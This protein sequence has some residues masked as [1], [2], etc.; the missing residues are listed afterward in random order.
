MIS[1]SPPAPPTIGHPL[2]LAS[3]QP[4]RQFPFKYFVHAVALSPDA[5][6]LAA[7]LVRHAERENAV[8]PG[9]S[10]ADTRTGRMRAL[11]GH[12]DTVTSLTFD[13]S[14]ARLA[15]A[16][17]NGT[18]FLWD[19]A[20]GAAIWR[21]TVPGLDVHGM[22]LPEERLAFARPRRGRTSNRPRSDGS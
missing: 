10:S 9:F 5:S 22:R 3:G 6:L 8:N 7:G 18:L 2:D 15:S 13:H 16:A 14:G 11:P 19:V 20:T 12:A 1:S 17:T 4:L 21:E